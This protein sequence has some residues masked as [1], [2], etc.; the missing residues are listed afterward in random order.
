MERDSGREASGEN[1]KGAEQARL[2]GGRICS[3]VGL[4]FGL[5][6]IVLVLLGGIA[7]VS[8]GAV[9]IGLGVLGYYLGSTRL[10]AAA[11]ILGIVALFFTVAVSAGI[12]PGLE[13]PGHG[14]PA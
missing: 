14:Y 2:L 1:R 3:L 8:S 9:G 6:V 12:I 5:G 7:G 13:P 11:V 4:L 10:G